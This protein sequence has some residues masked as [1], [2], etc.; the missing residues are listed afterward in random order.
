MPRPSLAVLGMLMTLIFG[1]ADPGGNDRVERTPAADPAPAAGEEDP[2]DRPMI[3]F[4]GTSLTAGYGILQ[5]QAYPGLIEE[6]LEREG[7][8]HE[9]E[10]AGVSG[11]TSA[12]A[13]RRVDWLLRRPFDVLVLETGA[14]DML[15]GTDPD[16]TRDNIQQIIDRVRADRPEVPIVL[17][18]MRAAPNLGR[19]YVERFDRIYQEL[20]EEN[21][22]ALVPFLLEEVGGER[23]MNLPD[24]VHPNPAGHER[25]AETVWPVLREVLRDAPTGG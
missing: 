16:D 10:N 4:V 18:G 23:E 2:A 21:D 14:N 15:R 17:L 3:L 9:V 20:A 25:M 13:L 24:G 19:E 11:E 5:D 8:P 1:C 6:R 22:L 12:G 7:F